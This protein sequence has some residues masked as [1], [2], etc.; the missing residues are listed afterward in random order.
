[1]RN[2]SFVNDELIRFAEQTPYVAFASAEGLTSNPDRLHFN[3]KSLQEFG[4][5]YYAA[6]K[7]VAKEPTCDG[8]TRIDDTKRREMELL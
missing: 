4:L 5:R 3:H 6:Y 8:I 2:Y 1:M 7:T